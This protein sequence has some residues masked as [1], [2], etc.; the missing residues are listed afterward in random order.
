M[1]SAEKQTFNEKI[2]LLII[3][4]NAFRKMQKLLF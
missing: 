1:S 2:I 4:L 3:E